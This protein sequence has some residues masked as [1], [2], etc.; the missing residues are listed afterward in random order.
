MV[1]NKIDKRK[2]QKLITVVTTDYVE[3]IVLDLLAKSFEVYKKRDFKSRN[4]G[5]HAFENTYATAAI[6]LTV[7]SIE[8]YRNRI[9]YLEREKVGRVAEDLSRIIR[10][11]ISSFPK[12]K[13]QEILEEVFVVRDVI[14]HNHIYE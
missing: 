14:V 13:F 12:E 3:S 1:K 10:R 8:S 5:L 6:V 2:T 9:F 11:K 7:L 4:Y